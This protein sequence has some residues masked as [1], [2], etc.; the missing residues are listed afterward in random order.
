MVVVV[1]VAAINNMPPS[2]L[3]PLDPL[4]SFFP[5]GTKN[6]YKSCLQ[7][8][9]WMIICI[10]IKFTRRAKYLRS[11]SKDDLTSLPLYRKNKEKSPESVTCKVLMTWPT[12]PPPGV[13]HPPSITPGAP[14]YSPKVTKKV[15]KMTRSHLAS[16]VMGKEGNRHLKS[17]TCLVLRLVPTL[18]P[19]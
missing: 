2:L 9:F 17:I 7:I 16:L 8:I 15:T 13:V 1:V 12:P 14:G 5:H 4:T 3:P 11:F 18:S 19:I 6:M 10:A